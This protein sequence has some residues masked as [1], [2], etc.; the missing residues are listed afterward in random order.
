MIEPVERR[1]YF[2]PHGAYAFDPLAAWR[3][4]VTG[5]G[6][7]VNEWIR[8]RKGD[9]LLKAAE[10]EEKLLALARRVFDLP[11]W[12]DED[13]KGFTDQEVLDTLAHFNGWLQGKGDRG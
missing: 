7:K 2:T 12:T 8:D 3:Q 6:G 5:S 9:D 10:S 4:L 1:I 11:A 13:P